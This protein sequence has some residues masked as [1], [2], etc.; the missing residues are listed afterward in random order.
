MSIVRWLQKQIM[1]QE[2]A[3]Q[4]RKMS[5]KP[6][7][8]SISRHSRLPFAGFTPSTPCSRGL[9]SPK[10]TLRRRVWLNTNKIQVPHFASCAAP[11][12]PVATHCSVLNRR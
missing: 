1:K 7:L 6:I 4:G 10:L 2:I 11:P 8:G 3:S 12:P 5:A 9:I